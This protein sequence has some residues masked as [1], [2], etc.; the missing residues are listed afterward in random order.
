MLFSCL[1]EFPNTEGLLP[2]SLVFLSVRMIFIVCLSDLGVKSHT[3][4]VSAGIPSEDNESIARLMRRV[5]YVFP[6]ALLLLD[7]AID[8]YPLGIVS[9]TSTFFL[10]CRLRLPVRQ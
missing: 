3:G 8:P 5:Q 1:G 6:K 2:S 4:N 7:P 9:V 10:C